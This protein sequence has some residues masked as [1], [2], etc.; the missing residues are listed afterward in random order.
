[1]WRVGER[2]KQE[3]GGS[4]S[5]AFLAPRLQHPH[6]AGRS[7]THV[8]GLALRA[9]LAAESDGGALALDG[10]SV[11][12]DVGDGDLHRRVV[13]GGDETVWESQQK[14]Q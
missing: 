9:D 3:A 13:L 11:R 7:S 4:P 12:V 5:T 10:L 1:M 6:L 14:T 2:A 8:V